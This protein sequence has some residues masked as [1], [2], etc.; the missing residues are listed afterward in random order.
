MK[1]SPVPARTTVEMSFLPVSWARLPRIPKIVVPAIKLVAR[2]MVV[3]NVQS[4]Q[5][6]FIKIF[7]SRYLIYRKINEILTNKLILFII[8]FSHKFLAIGRRKIVDAVNFNLIVQRKSQDGINLINKRLPQY[9]V[10]ETIVRGVHDNGA[11]ANSK[12]EEGL[13]DSR[14]PNRWMEDLL[15][16]W[17]E[18]EYYTV[19]GSLQR[20]CPDQKSYH[21][22]VWEQSEEIG[23]FPAALHAF[24]KHYENEQPTDEQCEDQSP[25]WIPQS[26]VYSSLVEHHFAELGLKK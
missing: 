11:E 20:H 10:V 22:R 9:V 19:P 25:R 14:V 24:A 8:K 17:F 12:G 16:S 21:D 4:L 2:S 7:F 18:K 1:A 15:P 6:R 26:F 3:T 5:L 23:R 13:S